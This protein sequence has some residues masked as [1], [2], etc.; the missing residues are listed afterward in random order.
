MPLPGRLARTG[1]A[2]R[3]VLPD[4]LRSRVMAPVYAMVVSFC[5]VLV[6][7]A[8]ADG[9]A[10]ADRTFRLVVEEGD[11][12]TRPATALHGSPIAVLTGGTASTVD[13][14]AQLTAGGSDRP[15]LVCVR[16]PAGWSAPGTRRWGDG[17]SCWEVQPGSADEPVDLPVR[18]PGG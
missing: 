2:R 15:L 16:L 12:S 4:G 6:L 1:G 3:A 8:V 5:A 18:A 7:G 17:Y 14:R 11:G 9:G 10:A 13:D